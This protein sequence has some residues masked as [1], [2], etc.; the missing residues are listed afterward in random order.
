MKFAVGYQEPENREL[1]SRIV[2]DYRDHICEV[3]FA[4]PGSPS[5]RAD[6]AR[7]GSIDRLED[8]LTAIRQM[9]VKLDLLFN[10]NCYG[11]SAISLDF[12]K[13]TL[14]RIGRLA[15]HRSAAGCRDH[16]FTLC[17]N[18]GQKTLAHRGNTG[19]GKYAHRQYR[20]HGVFKRYF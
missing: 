8:E 6:Y 1:F 5:G 9:G 2:A 17:G 10:A 12:E 11:G 3:Y 19:I 18:A 15:I 14:R 7:N 4:L 13:K 20:R 16:N